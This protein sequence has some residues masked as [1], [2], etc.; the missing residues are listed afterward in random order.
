MICLVRGIPGDVEP[1]K[2]V[3]DEESLQRLATMAKIKGIDLTIEAFN[4]RPVS[5]ARRSIVSR[6]PI[7][8]E[9][10]R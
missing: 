3:A 8:I 2:I 1:R 5:L 10:K 9:V 7:A 6:R 4:P